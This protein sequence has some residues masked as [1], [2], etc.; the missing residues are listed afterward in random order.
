MGILESAVEIAREFVAISAERNVL[1]KAQVAI[2]K[3]QLEIQE[4]KLSGS[5]PK[6]E[7][8]EVAIENTTTLNTIAPDNAGITSNG[9]AIAALNDLAETEAAERKR[10][11]ADIIAAGRGDEVKGCQMKKVREVFETLGAAPVAPVAV[12]ETTE[13]EHPNLFPP[14]AQ[15]AAV[16]VPEVVEAPV[17]APIVA[18]P[19]PAPVAAP[20]AEPVAIPA[21]VA[22]VVTIELV[23]QKLTSFSAKH[24]DAALGQLIMTYGKQPT[25]GQVD[26]A[27]YAALILASGE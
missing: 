13:Q 10:K 17:V 2:S 1:H 4:S 21:F 27:D 7:A 25:L 11:V 16:V 24:G 15:P 22:P 26:P 8:V 5:E 23:K 18:A 6:P 14:V 9:V 19:A 20:V 12:V 3:R